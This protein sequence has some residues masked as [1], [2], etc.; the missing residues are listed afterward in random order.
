MMPPGEVRHIDRSLL[1]TLVRGRVFS[2]LR[3]DGVLGTSHV[4]PLGNP[5]R[6]DGR[7]KRAADIALAKRTISRAS[8]DAILAGRIGIHEAKAIGRHGTPAADTGQAS[9]GPGTATGR[10]RSASTRGGQDRRDVPPQP[11]SR[12]SKDDRR[13][14]CMCGCGKTTRVR[15][16]IGQDQRLLKFAYEHLRGKRELTEEQLAYVQDETDKLKRARKR[17]EGEEQKSRQKG[18]S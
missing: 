3:R 2:E 8:Y 17:V 10:A 6:L 18:D 11:V 14:E 7:T 13:R 16:A 9:S 4:R 15:F 5:P 12:I 1:F